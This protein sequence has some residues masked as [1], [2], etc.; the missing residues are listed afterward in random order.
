VASKLTQWIVALACAG[1]MM[2][3]VLASAA[4]VAG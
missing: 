1:V 3:F 4:H 2:A